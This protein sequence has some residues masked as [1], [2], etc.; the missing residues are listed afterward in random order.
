MEIT[1]A[2]VVLDK[3]QWSMSSKFF[4]HPSKPRAWIGQLSNSTLICLFFARNPIRG[5]VLG[6]I[7]M[8]RTSHLFIPCHWWFA[9]AFHPIKWT[10]FWYPHCRCSHVDMVKLLQSPLLWFMWLLSLL[11]YRFQYFVRHSTSTIP[12]PHLHFHG[13]HLLSTSLMPKS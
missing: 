12:P 8:S 7:L 2:I 3:S 9:S 11:E 6:K 13:F 10:T 4:Y 1:S 5:H